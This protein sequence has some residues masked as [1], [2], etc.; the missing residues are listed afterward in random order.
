MLGVGRGLNVMFVFS[1]MWRKGVVCGV[2]IM[3]YFIC[4]RGG[5]FLNFGIYL[6]IWCNVFCFVLR[7]GKL[8]VLC[9][10]GRNIRI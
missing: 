7:K 6:K 1:V 3:G 10:I 8:L 4:V 2:C 9:W 5:N